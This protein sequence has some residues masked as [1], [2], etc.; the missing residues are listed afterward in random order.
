MN[1]SGVNKKQKVGEA[2]WMSVKSTKKGDPLD[3]GSL[4]VNP[5]GREHVGVWQFKGHFFPVLAG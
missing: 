4:A 2:P 3:L 1:E 5:V